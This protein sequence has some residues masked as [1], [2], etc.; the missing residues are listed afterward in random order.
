[1]KTFNQFITETND[2][3]DRLERRRE[4][5]RDKAKTIAADFKSNSK[6][7]QDNQKQKHMDVRSKYDAWQ[8]K[9][10]AKRLRGRR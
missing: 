2:A 5:A 4:I 9:L 8:R 7:K 1:M 10:K 3:A 6:Q